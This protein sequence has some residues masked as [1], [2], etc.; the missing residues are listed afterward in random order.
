MLRINRINIWGDK[1]S[2]PKPTPWKPRTTI[3]FAQLQMF[4]STFAN[5]WKQNYRFDI[6]F[7]RSLTNINSTTVFCTFCKRVW[8]FSVAKFSSHSAEKF[9]RGTRLSFRKFRVSKNFMPKRGISRFSIENFFS[10]ST[11]NLRRGPF[12]VSQNS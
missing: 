8:R 10:H 9:R 2:N 6:G 3:L 7:Q 12:F 1:D 5:G 11:E 4:W